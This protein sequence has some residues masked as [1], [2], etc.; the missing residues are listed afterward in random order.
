MPFTNPVIPGFHPDP[1][2]CRVGQDYYLVTSS[3]EYFPGVP[4][5]HSRDLVHW[6]Q[7]GHVLTRDSQLPLEGCR[8]SGGIY[9][10]TIRHHDGVF[11][12]ITTNVTGGGNFLVTATDPA[13]PWSEPVWLDVGGIDPSLFFNDDGQCYLQGNAPTD[14]KQGITMALIDPRNGRVLR[15]PEHVWAGTGGRYPEAP[16]L[17][18]IGGKYHLMIAEGGTEYGHMV[19]VARADTPWG[20][21]ESCPHNPILSHRNHG[22]SQIQG[23]GHGD[24]VQAHDGSWWIV[25]L[26]F[27]QVQPMFHNLGRETFLAPVEWVDGWPLVNGGRPITE[28]MDTPTLPSAPVPAP[29]S[30]DDFT[31]PALSPVWNHLRNPNREDYSLSA[32]PGWLRLAGSE[33]TLDSLASPTFVGRRQ[34][35]HCCEAS[36]LLRFEPTQEGEEAG[37][38]VFYD[39]THHYD[40]AVTMQDGEKKIVFNKVVG[41]ISIVDNAIPYNGGAVVL[42]VR[43]DRE[44][45]AFSFSAD[46]ITLQ[47]GAG[48]TVFLTSE[49]CG[50][51]FTGVYIGLYA[52]GNGERCDAPAF[53]DWFDYKPTDSTSLDTLKE[54]I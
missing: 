47:A 12:M 19:T 16:H 28:T 35:H 4:V 14:G 17:Y 31:A 33:H 20:P 24:L 1:S 36:T 51:S 52:T 8:P 13:G 7:I 10:P 49:A 45:Y 22:H 48:N 15:G 39:A 21:F 44:R 38:T 6:R 46:G 34:Q 40:L 5:F 43:A 25:F 42:T 41:D 32:R 23:T 37:L 54:G 26:A 18:K 50:V 11:Y 53:F 27:R 29:P 3:F 30:R 2:V 9:A